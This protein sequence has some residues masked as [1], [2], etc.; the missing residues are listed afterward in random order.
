MRMP[1]IVRLERIHLLSVVQDHAYRSEE[2]L[3]VG[4]FGD[5]MCVW[6]KKTKSGT[7]RQQEKGTAMVANLVPP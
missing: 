3:R 1:T 5:T 2:C 4:C 6:A 7:R